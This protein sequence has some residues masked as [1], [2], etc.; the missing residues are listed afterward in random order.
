MPNEEQPTSS[1]GGSS[2]PTYPQTGQKYET[3]P[4]IIQPPEFWS[5]AHAIDVPADC[6]NFILN[7]SN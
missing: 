7:L 6:R 2:S 4:A 5:L 1:Y 3:L